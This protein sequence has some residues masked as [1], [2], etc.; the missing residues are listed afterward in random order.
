M[1]SISIDPTPDHAQVVRHYVDLSYEKAPAQI[2]TLTKLL[3]PMVPETVARGTLLPN[4]FVSLT[5]E[6]AQR[7]RCSTVFAP[8]ESHLPAFLAYAKLR[9]H[10]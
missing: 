10:E 5:R 4:I 1:D 2:S 6:I 3:A 9:M 8:H 7:E